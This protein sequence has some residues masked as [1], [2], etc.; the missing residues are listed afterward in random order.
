MSVLG[1]GGMATVYLARDTTLDRDVALKVLDWTVDESSASRLAQEARI[2][3][4]LEHPG[5]V[6]VTTSVCSPTAGCSTR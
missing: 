1:R 4:H 2:L 3:A 6:P 5:I